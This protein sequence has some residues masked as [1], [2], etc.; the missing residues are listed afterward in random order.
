MQTAWNSKLATGSR[1]KAFTV[2][3]LE[4]L[5]QE[6]QERF[7]SILNHC[8]DVVYRRNLQTDRYD[9]VSP[10]VYEITG[11]T[12][13]EFMSD[14]I[15]ATLK[16]VHP[17][18]LENAERAIAAVLASP[19]GKGKAQYRYLRKD[20]Q[21]RWFSDHY[22]ITRD[23]DG[24]LLYWVGTVRDIT[25]LKEAEAAYE[26]LL[27]SLETKVAQR[28][29]QLAEMT[30]KIM[31]AEEM[32]RDRIGHILHEEALQILTGLHCVLCSSPSGRLDEKKTALAQDMVQNAITVIGSLTG[33]LIPPE[34][35][36]D[37]MMDGIAW[38]AENAFQRFGLKINFAVE[39]VVEPL[40]EPF[41]IFIFHSIYEL[42]L[43][44]YKH[45]GAHEA[46]L[47][48]QASDHEWMRIEIRDPG[49][50]FDT[51][52][53]IF[54]GFGLFRIR[55]RSAM[56]GGSLQVFSSEGKGCTVVLILPRK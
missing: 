8:M 33:Q 14:G 24:K 32:E 17:E 4:A 27:A 44:I 51:E 23:K 50:G 47:N 42:I 34:L 46:W 1:N 22:S 35:M 56:L 52:Q 40:S 19:S 43:N 9:Y 36:E 13:E 18:D 54:N 45:S 25:E 41:R 12:P 38:L 21:Y 53:K 29:A 15:A 28:T 5:L 31:R 48:I 11:Y 6:S 49:K 2:Q 7:H 30:M 3:K 16:R 10:S 20:G 26:K 55:E 37:N 39:G